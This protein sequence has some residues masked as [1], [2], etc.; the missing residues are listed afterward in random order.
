MQRSYMFFVIQGGKIT[1]RRPGVERRQIK[2]KE[3]AAHVLSVL[4][5]RG[6]STSPFYWGVNVHAHRFL[7]VKC[8]FGMQ[9]IIGLYFIGVAASINVYD[10]QVACHSHPPPHSY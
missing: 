6:G 8:L 10:F 3:P 5:Q 4:F 1:P 2:H 7:M 9:P